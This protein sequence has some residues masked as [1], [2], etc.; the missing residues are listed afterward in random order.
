MPIFLS[1]SLGW[2]HPRVVKSSFLHA[3]PTCLWSYSFLGLRLLPIWGPR[4]IHLGT[5]TRFLLWSTQLSPPCATLLFI[6]CETMRSQGPWGGSW[7]DTFGVLDHS[8]KI[9]EL[10]AWFLDIHKEKESEICSAQGAYILCVCVFHPAWMSKT[11]IYCSELSFQ[12]L[13]LSLD[14]SLL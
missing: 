9:L 4:L 12:D 5:Q 2:Q 8:P 11:Q 1:P 6:V 7:R 10:R 14:G 13:V 3:P